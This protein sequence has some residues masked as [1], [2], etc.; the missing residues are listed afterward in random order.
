M[1][2]QRQHTRTLKFIVG[3]GLAYTAQANATNGHLLHGIG[4]VNQSMGGA[5]IA[6][7]IDAI[8]SNYNNVSSIS[9]LDKSSLELGLEL[10]M[11]DR[12][13]SA[14]IDG[15]A[16]GTVESRT[17]ETPIPSLGLVYKTGGPWTFGLTAVGIAGMGVDY[18]ANLPNPQGNFNPLALPQ[19]QGGFGAI[20]SNYQ[21]LQV[22]PSAAYLLTPKLSLGAGINI[23]WHSLAADPWPATPPNGSGFPSA[24]HDATA[25]GW[26]F[27]VGATYRPLSNLAVGLVFKSPQWFQDLSWNS[28]FPDGTPTSFKFRLNFPLIVGGGISY[29][30][31][32]DLLLAADLKWINYRN[33][34]G[35]HDR[36]FGT[37][38]TGPFVRG[39]GWED[40]FAFSL[41]GQYK[42]TPRITLRAGYNYNDNPV[43]QEQQFFNVPFPAIVQHRLTAGLGIE[44]VSNLLL[45]IAYYHALENEESGP[46]IST[47]A[48]GFPPRNQPVP[49]TRV[50]NRLSEDAVSA[51]LVYK[52]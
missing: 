2:E 50:T 47:G 1:H 25:W 20:Y 35:F 13:F 21:M 28:Q 33:T 4:A 34:E 12:E 26:G 31:T 8:G 39:F 49:G 27:T 45:N 44:L 23:D 51:Q 43:P 7:S 48:A 14:S 29:Q 36:N 19:N 3:L 22:T 42:L 46:I 17:R 24:T 6:T 30:P 11:P 9:F 16:S 52:F 15:T 5:G 18:P 38:A 32:D 10:F 40:V 37:S 41:G